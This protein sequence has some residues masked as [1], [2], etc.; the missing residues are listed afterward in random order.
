M[1]SII[2]KIPEYIS[3]ARKASA[4]SKPERTWFPNRKQQETLQAIR[5]QNF[6]H[7]IQQHL[8]RI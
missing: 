4:V 2:Q 6:Q 3:Q 5:Q 8:Q 7:S 1:P